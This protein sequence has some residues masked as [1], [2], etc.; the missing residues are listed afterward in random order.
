VHQLREMKNN[1]ANFSFQA[2]Q[3]L[4]EY[5]DRLIEWQQQP[6]RAK[7]LFKDD[8]EQ[9]RF[10]QSQTPDPAVT[11]QQE[12]AAS[13]VEAPAAGE[14]RDDTTEFSRPP[15]APPGDEEF[16]HPPVTAAAV[17]QRIAPQ[18]DDDGR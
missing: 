14:P 2:E 6:K 5:R 16:A 13:R 4:E 15:A 7:R 1:S 12:W 9:W 8:L 18:A 10:E 11:R 17:R 3:T